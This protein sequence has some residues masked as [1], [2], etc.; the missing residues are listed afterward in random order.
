MYFDN[1]E[2]ISLHFQI[3]QTLGLRPRHLLILFKKHSR[4]ARRA[5][6]TYHTTVALHTTVSLHTLLVIL[7]T[8]SVFVQTRGLATSSTNI[9]VRPA[10]PRI[11][12]IRCISS[13]THHAYLTYTLPLPLSTITHTP[14]GEYIVTPRPMLTTHRNIRPSVSLLF[15][16][17]IKLSAMHLHP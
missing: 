6:D 7:I 10:G 8:K 17:V 1:E 11:P 4:S 15:R 14:F 3:V 5:A 9:A 13:H 12:T 2:C 16:S